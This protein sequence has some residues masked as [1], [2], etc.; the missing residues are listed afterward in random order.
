M[1]IELGHLS[2]K[3]PAITTIHVGKN[4]DDAL[5]LAFWRKY[6]HVPDIDAGEQLLA[7]ADHRLLTQIDVAARRHLIHIAI[8]EEFAIFH[9]IECWT[10]NH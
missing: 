2:V 1:F 7:N 3:L 10:A 4:V 5:G 6:D 8:K 9:H